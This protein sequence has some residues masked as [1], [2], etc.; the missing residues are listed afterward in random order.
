MFLLPILLAFIPALARR[1]RRAR[2]MIISGGLLCVAGELF[3][4]QKAIF[5]ILFAPIGN[6]ILLQ[7]G[8][9]DIALL[10]D[11]RVARLAHDLRLVVAAAVI[12]ALLAIFL[13]TIGR[14]P[15]AAPETPSPIS[16]QSL[17]ILLAPFSL[18]Y[19]GLL[20]SRGAFVGIYDR[21]LLPLLFVGVLILLRFFQDRVQPGLPAVSL[22]L[23]GLFAT[24]AVAGTHDV[25]SGYRAQIAA[26]AEL[27][28]AGIPDNAIDAGMEHDLLIHVERFGYV[29]SPE[30]STPLPT[31][32]AALPESCQ[33][34]SARLAPEM[35]PGYKLSSDPE[36]CG[37]PSGFA[38]VAYSG[39]LGLYTSTLYI[40]NTAK[41]ASTQP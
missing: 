41:L 21:H 7:D 26:I 23:V 18:A 40:D 16:G 5:N 9:A 25:F 1:S 38:P 6:Y 19:L 12:L 20:L 22:V 30:L 32:F 11:S 34:R 27:R 14:R 31:Q 13:L 37:G 8:F 4:Q 10:R 24:Y 39:W 35:V 15:A 33:P 17:L 3:L 2:A 29:N 28:A 36:A